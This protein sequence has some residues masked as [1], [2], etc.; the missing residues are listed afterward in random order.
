MWR[1]PMSLGQER[2]KA[3][4]NK[5][6]TTLSPGF[7]ISAFALAAAAKDKRCA[8]RRQI[9]LAV[10][11]EKKYALRGRRQI[12]LA[13]AKDKRYAFAQFIITWV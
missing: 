9:A 1:S 4:L 3:R 6:I 7:I 12:V 13:V 5:T 2:V 10:V 8:G 11:K